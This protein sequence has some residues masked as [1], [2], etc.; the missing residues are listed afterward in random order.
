MT[1]VDYMVGK[2]LIRFIEHLIYYLIFDEVSQVYPAKSKMKEIT[3][4]S[5]FAQFLLFLPRFLLLFC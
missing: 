5:I 2:P 1:H 3:F 4:F